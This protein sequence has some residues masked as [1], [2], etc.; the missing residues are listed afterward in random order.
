MSAQIP[1]DLAPELLDEFFAEA[2]EHLTGIREALIQ[3]EAS[4]GKPEPDARILEELSLQIHSFKGISAIAGLAPGEAVAHAAE[5]LLR[6]LM[7]GKAVLTR[8]GLESLAAAAQKLEQVVAAYRLRQPMP[9]LASFLA[10]LQQQCAPPSPSA[11]AP[12]LEPSSTS[13]SDPLLLAKIEAAKE[14]GL[15]WKYSF[16]PSR[17]LD[18]QGVNVNSVRKRL[19]SAGEIL[20]GTPIVHGTAITFEFLVATREAP[21]DLSAWEAQ[22][23]RVQP[24]DQLPAQ[25]SPD[26]LTATPSLGEVESSPFLAPSHVVR[27]DLKRLD[28]LMRITSELVIHRSRLD[29]QLGRLN[30]GAGR[31]DLSGVHEVSINLGRSLRE[32]REAIT[33]VR[34]VPVAEIFAR[35]PFV[36]RDLARQTQKR[37]R[38]KF[39]GQATAIDKYLIERLKDPLL[40]LVRNA[41][42]HGVEPPQERAAAGKPEEATIELKASTVG[43]SVVIQVRDDGQGIDPGAI[44]QRAAKLGLE[45]PPTADQESILKILCATGFSTRDDADRAA[46]RGVGMAVV[47]AAVR[48]LGGH[49][50]LESTPGRGTQFTLRLPLTLAIAETLIVSAAG[51]TCAVPQS[52]VTEI[53]HATEDQVQ[54]VNGIEVIPF[55]AGVLPIVRLSGLFRL[56]GAAKPQRYLLVITSER[57]SVG[58]LTEEVLGRR[59]VVVSALR[60]PL[61]RVPAVS[62]A[63]ELGDGKP[64]LILDGAALTA[65]HVRPPERFTTPA[66]R[67]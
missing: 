37:V 60:D 47:S 42:S 12:T 61:T 48:D 65:G 32:L 9:E 53:L 2:D 46:G 16:S 54:M 17:E 7:R 55:R 34:L 25:P 21:A 59:E 26:A 6:V 40:H 38:L 10:N 30:G 66:E 28:E 58:L 67:N 57:G 8:E 14:R 1:C 5:D 49:L 23:I 43:D 20:T 18:A 41:F 19:S 24:A 45:L 33:R 11:A 29:A 4:V 44:V 50:A 31:T 36:V 3:L 51:Q 39:E 56:G 27:V 62:G 35:M 15:L 22:G 63:T 64:V 52:F 13:A